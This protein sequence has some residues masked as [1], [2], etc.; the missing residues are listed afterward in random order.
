[1]LS[2]R[3]GVIDVTAVITAEGENMISI[4]EETTTS[5]VLAGEVASTATEQPDPAR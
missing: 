1:L 2:G 5:P 3:T 4:A